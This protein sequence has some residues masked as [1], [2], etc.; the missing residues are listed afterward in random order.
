MAVDTCAA[1]QAVIPIKVTLRA[2]QAGM[3]PRQREAGAGVIEGR[4]APAR[5]VV[6]LLARLGEIGHHVIRVGRAPVI[7][8]VTGGAGVVGEVIVVV[9]VAIGALAWRNSMRASQRKTS[10][11]VVEAGIGPGRG[12][13]TS[14]AGGGDT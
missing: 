1:G 11:R 7:L 3:R 5:G 13:V 8:E 9:N 4:S 14:S 2:L 10:G 12:V 6:A